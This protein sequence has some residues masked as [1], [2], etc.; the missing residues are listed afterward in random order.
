MAE[1]AETAARYPVDVRN[2]RGEYCPVPADEESRLQMVTCLGVRERERDRGKVLPDGQ[3]QADRRSSCLQVTGKD[4]DPHL[5]SMVS[6]VCSVLKFPMGGVPPV[7][8]VLLKMQVHQEPAQ[9]GL[10]AGGVLQR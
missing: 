2:P 6:L 7:P 9:M 4:E 10:K 8:A 3:P 5:K 1:A